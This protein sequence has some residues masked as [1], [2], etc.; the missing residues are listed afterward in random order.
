M[1]YI[2]IINISTHSLIKQIYKLEDLE[3]MALSYSF[4]KAI[5]FLAATAAL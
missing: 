4:R 1:K 2:M 3:K 5:I